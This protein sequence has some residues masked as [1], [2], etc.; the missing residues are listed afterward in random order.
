MKLKKLRSKLQ[1]G[2]T[3][4]AAWVGV[5]ILGDVVMRKRRVVSQTKHSMVTE[6]LDGPNQSFQPQLFWAGISAARDLDVITLL[7]DE[8][9]AFLTIENIQETP[10]P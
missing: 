9:K 2:T 4:N 1:P 7:D 10:Q 6:I 5:G 3:F 8:D